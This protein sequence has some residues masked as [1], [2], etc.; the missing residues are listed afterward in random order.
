MKFVDILR[1]W[2]GETATP[3]ID[4]AVAAL[5]KRH[6]ARRDGSKPSRYALRQLSCSSDPG[7]ILVGPGS[8]ICGQ[9]ESY[10][11]ATRNNFSYIE[12]GRKQWFAGRG[13]MTLRELKMQAKI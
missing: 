10:A 13:R 3:A 5:S 4:A 2:V 11:A 7:K 9:M 8:S 6:N 12:C 1:H